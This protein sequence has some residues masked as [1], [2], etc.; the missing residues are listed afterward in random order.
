MSKRNI[1]VPPLY[2]QRYDFFKKFA[3]CCFIV[4]IAFN[5]L[6]Y[7]FYKDD[8]QNNPTGLLDEQCND[9][10]VNDTKAANTD[11]TDANVLPEN[12]DILSSYIN[13]NNTKEKLSKRDKEINKKY[14]GKPNCKFLFAYYLPEQET[15]ANANYR[16]FVTLAEKLD[17][18]MVLTNVGNSRI[19]SCQNLTF[20]FYY[21][22]DELKKMYPDVK[23]ITQQ[24]FRDWSRER[25]KK[26]NTEHAYI[27]PGDRNSTVELVNPYPDQLKEGF[28]LNLFDFN[29][30]DKT[31]FKQFHTGAKFYREIKTHQMFSDLLVNNLITNVDVLLASHLIFHPLFPEIAPPIPYAKHFLEESKRVSTK[32]HPYIAVH[33]RMERA[34]LSLLKEC[35]T[36]LV[37]KIKDISL[38]YGIKNVYLATDYPLTGGAQSSTFDLL[39]DLHHD[40]IRYL[41]SS[42]NVDNWV[43]M[44]VFGDLRKN[45][46]FD[47]EFSGAGMPGIVDKLICINS[48]FFLAT[49]EGCGRQQST[50]TTMI[51]DQRNETL[52]NLDNITNIKDDNNDIDN[53]NILNVVERWM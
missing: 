51:I 13:T 24:D 33:W 37:E 10:K 21:D 6:G 32:L 20:D 3:I 23:F 47:S 12:N 5:G 30:N 1:T 18:I 4:F 43:T 48:K 50:F 26:P 42:V 15:K 27:L 14:C 34:T 28:C 44:D 22:V 11:I 38:M 35:S 36:R 2:V 8:L 19:N 40:A 41:N 39:T 52:L 29:L 16:S 49:P 7:L 46:T 53:D 9:V 45:K 17:R 31:I 25:H